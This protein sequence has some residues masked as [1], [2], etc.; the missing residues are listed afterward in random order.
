MGTDVMEAITALLYVWLAALQAFD[1][2]LT[3]RVLAEGGLS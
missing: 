2:W 1:A 3:R